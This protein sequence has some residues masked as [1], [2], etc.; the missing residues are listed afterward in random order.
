MN[1]RS[2][3][4]ARTKG[5]H[6]K[7]PRGAGG[8]RGD[9]SVAEIV[10]T[11]MRLARHHTFTKLSMRE[12]AEA[13]NVQPPAIYYHLPNR[14]A[15]LDLTAVNIIRGVPQPDS[16]LPWRERLRRLILALRDTFLEYPGLGRYM[17]CTPSSIA[18]ALWYQMHL[19]ILHDAGFDRASA[20][21]AMATLQCYAN[22]VNMLDEADLAATQRFDQSAW[23]AVIAAHPEEYRDLADVLPVLPKVSFETL[24]EMGLSSV[25]EGLA[26][27]AAHD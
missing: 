23:D 5:S 27:D 10:R 20:V 4:A 16:A 25:I 17:L 6:A 1:A 15:L 11:A 26:A 12:L 14:Q 18:N 24:Y 19:N 13:L 7:K 8:G 9:L 21:R 3:I 2:G 22:P